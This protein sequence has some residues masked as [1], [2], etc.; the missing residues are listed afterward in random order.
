MKNKADNKSKDEISN[1]STIVKGSAFSAVITL[2]L[3]FIYSCIL[4]Y[5]NVSDTTI[6]VVVII[7]TIVSIL[8]GSSIATNRIKNRGLVNGAFVGGIYISLIYLLSSFLETGFS[9]NFYS[10]IM[11]V[12]GILA[13]SIGGI[14]GV[15]IRR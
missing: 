1:I 7:L 10:I 11:I 13:G 9:F 6:P 2:I 4:A 8:I 12:A 3:L 14:M 15:N 5:T